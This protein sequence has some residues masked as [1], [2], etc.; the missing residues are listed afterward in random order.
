MDA[1]ELADEPAL[2]AYPAPCTADDLADLRPLSRDELP[3]D[4]A[5]LARFLIGATLV[6]EVDGERLAG[7]VVETEAYVVG[8]AAS[9]CF[10]GMTERNRAMFLERGHAYVYIAYGVWPA[11]NVSGEVAGVGAG[12]LFRALEPV[13]GTQRMRRNRGAENLRDLAR[14]PGRLA[15]ALEIGLDLN[16]TDLCA[17]GPLWLAPPLRPPGEV[18][19]SVRI[20]IT[21]EAHRPLR[22]FER[23]SPYLSGPKRLSP[24]MEP[25]AS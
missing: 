10:R 15:T 9:H 18:G 19:A 17:P 20:G 13:L 8:D 7:R 6:R 12:V 24:G 25:T 4:A 2:S 11:L 16:G 3:V 21:K 1:S 5:A 22:F 14:G 23:G